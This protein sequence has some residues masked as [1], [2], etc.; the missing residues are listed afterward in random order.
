M[1]SISS[2]MG[3]TRTQPYTQVDFRDNLNL[4]TVVFQG[5]PVWRTSCKYMCFLVFASRLS[6]EEN[7]R[8]MA[9]IYC[10]G[11]QGKRRVI[12]SICELKVNPRQNQQRKSRARPPTKFF[13]EGHTELGNCYIVHQGLFCPTFYGGKGIRIYKCRKLICPSIIGCR[14]HLLKK[15]TYKNL[16]GH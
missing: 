9:K 15:G 11:T 12:G 2:H 4:Y 10:K 1:S 13:K 3:H 5:F 16:Q 6:E 7:K 8:R 14:L